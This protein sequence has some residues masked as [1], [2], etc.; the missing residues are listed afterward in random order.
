MIALRGAIHSGVFS[1][2]MF[3]LGRLAMPPIDVSVWG[4]ATSFCRAGVVVERR[5]CGRKKEKKVMNLSNIKKL[6]VLS[7]CPNSGKS[8]ILKKLCKQVDSSPHMTA[9]DPKEQE[10]ANVDWRYAVTFKRRKLAIVT[11]GDDADAIFKAFMYAEEVRATIL[12]MALSIHSRGYRTSEE[13]F[14]LIVRHFNLTPDRSTKTKLNSH[15]DQKVASI[16][17]KK[18]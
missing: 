3:L 13:A 10:V 1:S 17:F 8:T 14:D 5:L 6:I 12:V 9:K 7:G 2:F 18:I 15:N 4:H 11:G 16:L